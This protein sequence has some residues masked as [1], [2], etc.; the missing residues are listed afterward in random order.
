MS[1]GR[2]RSS[3]SLTRVATDDT[4]ACALAGRARLVRA[5]VA[6][7]ISMGWF[8]VRFASFALGFAAGWA[9]RTCAESP[10]S[11]ALSVIAA[12]LSTVDRIKRALAIEKD[13][14]E[15]L[16]A[17]ARVRADVL[18]QERASRERPPSAR[19]PADE[20]AA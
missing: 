13:Q 2:T 7:L 16:V 9:A 1:H 12:A 4:F 19:T 18:R 14:L 17:E 20:A 10:R 15:D 3:I 6:R 5:D 11:T 8:M